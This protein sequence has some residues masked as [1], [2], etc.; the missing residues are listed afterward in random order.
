MFDKII[1]NNEKEI[2]FPVKAEYYSGILKVRFS[3]NV[4]RYI[5]VDSS[6]L[7]KSGLNLLDNLPKE[8]TIERD[9]TII[10]D[11]KRKIT[12]EEAWKKGIL[13]VNARPF[14]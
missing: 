13:S 2:P 14:I 7:S 8:M 1:P 5:K 3:N 4:D 11:E 12:A 6:L 9:G 10:L